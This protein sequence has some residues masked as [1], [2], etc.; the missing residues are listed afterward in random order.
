MKPALIIL[1]AM[2]VVGLVLYILDR[3]H[4]QPDEEKETPVVKPKST[5]NDECCSINDV[6]PSEMMLAGIDKEIEYYDDEELD[7]FAG[8]HADQYSD[9]EIEQFR[10]ILYTLQPKDLIGWERSVKKRGIIMPAP[11]HD[12]FIMLVNENST[13]QPTSNDGNI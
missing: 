1:A 9:E 6:C 10:D 2:V 12:E 5:C 8:R 11:I 4:R 13:Q 7:S 3:F